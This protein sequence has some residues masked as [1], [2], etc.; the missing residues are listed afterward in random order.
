V[1]NTLKKYKRYQAWL[2]QK[3]NQT[4]SFE[5]VIEEMQNSLS[6]P[7]SRTRVKNIKRALLIAQTLSLDKSYSQAEDEDWGLL[8]MRES[9]GISPERSAMQAEASD[10]IKALF[11]EAGLDFR[12]KRVLT[13]EK[14][15]FGYRRH[16]LKEIG[17]AFGLSRERI[18]QIRNEAI[19][20]IRDK[21]NNQLF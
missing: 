21:A 12:E 6:D 7:I 15:L 10:R 3:H 5:E 8:N 16:T 17:D 18:R 20:K 19:E 2:E 11:S 14:G 1:H 9:Q 4:P 13:L